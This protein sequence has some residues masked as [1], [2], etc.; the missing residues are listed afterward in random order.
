MDVSTRAANLTLAEGARRDIGRS[1][2]LGDID[3]SVKMGSRVRA[4]PAVYSSGNRPAGEVVVER[5][6]FASEVAFVPHGDLLDGATVAPLTAPMSEQ[7][8]FQAAI[9]RFAPGG[10]LARHS[11][12]ALEIFAVLDGSG[13]VI[14]PDAVGE[15]ISVGEAI[16]WSPGDEQEMHSA[17]GMSVLVIQGE[18]LDR[19]RRSPAT[20]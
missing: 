8:P 13:E 19:F 3:L 1:H 11:A 9:F 17:T 7:S 10:R 15:P 14:G 18:Q 5:F 12:T 6:S 20:R 4:T 2:A 16:F